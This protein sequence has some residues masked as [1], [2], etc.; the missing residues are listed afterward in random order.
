[1]LRENERERADTAMADDPSF[2][3]LWSQFD[4]LDAAIEAVLAT[5]SPSD[6]ELAPVAVADVQATAGLRGGLIGL[7]GRY[8]LR[9]SAEARH[10][11]PP[12]RVEERAPA[13][14]PAPTLE[15]DWL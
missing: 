3:D 4:A 1:M 9:G 11:L 2:D 12:A 14:E 5:R 15:P 13:G 7:I 8:S 10:E 6:V